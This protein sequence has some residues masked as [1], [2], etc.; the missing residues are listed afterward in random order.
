MITGAFT[1]VPTALLLVLGATTP[2]PGSDP[3]VGSE[4]G[5]DA[6]ITI[7]Q[8]PDA[9]VLDYPV[10][11]L[12]L[13]VRGITFPTA[14]GDGAVIDEG[15]NDFVLE[16]D[17]LFGF[18]RAT[19]TARARRELATIGAALTEDAGQIHRVEVLGHTDDVGADT[20][21][22]DLSGRRAQAVRR[23]LARHLPAGITLVARGRGES[24]PVADNATASGRRHNR[25]VEIRSR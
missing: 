2:E 16:S 10:E 15:D 11:D 20:Y 22:L 3:G 4:A 24:D 19:L 13:P 5:R 8:P 7:A 9:E 23:E 14:S 17:V 12:T 6:T 25:R 18:D 1:A 21:N